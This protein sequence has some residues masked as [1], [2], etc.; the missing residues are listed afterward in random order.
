MTCSE[1]AGLRADQQTHRCQR[2]AASEV[3]FM[4]TW[5]PVCWQHVA[6]HPNAPIRQLGPATTIS[7]DGWIAA[8]WSHAELVEAFGR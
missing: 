1:F 4:G 8:G 7:Y 5:Q 6:R 2:P 3:L